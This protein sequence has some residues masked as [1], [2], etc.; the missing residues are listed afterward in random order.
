MADYQKFCR[1]WLEV[2]PDLKTIKLKC[3]STKKINAVQGR[4]HG[5]VTY[6]E[7]MYP[8]QPGFNVSYNPAIRNLVVWNLTGLQFEAKRINTICT[9]QDAEGLFRHDPMVKF[10]E[11]HVGGLNWFGGSYHVITRDWADIVWK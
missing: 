5:V 9:I 3:W 7:L 8:G 6:E 4:L 10:D 2:Q 1:I 11:I